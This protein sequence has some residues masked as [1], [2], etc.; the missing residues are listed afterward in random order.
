MNE[1]RTSTKFSGATAALRGYEFQ[2]YSIIYY[3]LLRLEIDPHLKVAI[4]TAQDA[5]IEYSA[6]ES[7]AVTELVQCKKEEQRGSHGV[8]R[9]YRNDS[10]ELGQFTLTDLRDWLQKKTEGGLSVKSV[11]GSQQSTF[12]TALLLTEASSDLK[13]FA[14]WKPSKPSDVRLWERPDF[15]LCFP[16]AFRHPRDQIR[17]LAKNIATPAIREKIRVLP[18]A[19]WAELGRA[20]EMLLREKFGIPSANIQPAVLKLRNEYGIRTLAKDPSEKLLTGAEIAHVLDDFRVDRAQWTDAS[21]WLRRGA[22]ALRPSVPDARLDWADFEAGRYVERLEFEHAERALEEDGFV[23]IHGHAGGGKTSLARLLAYRLLSRDRAFRG[24]VLEIKPGF[25]LQGEEHFLDANLGKPGVFLIE[26]SHFA[27][28]EVVELLEVFHAAQM[29]RRTRA[30]V[31]VTTAERYGPRQL[32]NREKQNDPHSYAAAFNFEPL[33][34]AE[35]TDFIDRYA[36]ARGFHMPLPAATVAGLAGGRVAVALVILR[37]ALDLA[38]RASVQKLL[39]EEAVAELLRDWILDKTGLADR[40]QLFEK[41]LVPVF[42]VTAF[43]IAPGTRFAEGIEILVKAGLRG[44]EP[45]VADYALS[46]LIT[47]HYRTHVVQSFRTLIEHDWRSIVPVLQRLAREPA[48]RTVLRELLDGTM[49]YIATT[50]SD[51][52]RCMSLGDVAAVLN[53]AHRVEQAHALFGEIAAPGGD[54]NLEFWDR[55]CSIER[56]SNAASIGA[57]FNAL[58]NANRYLLRRLARDSRPLNERHAELMIGVLLRSP[59]LHDIAV[60]LRG[61]YRYSRDFAHL[62][63]DQLEGSRIFQQRMRDAIQDMAALPDLVRYCSTLYSID[64]QRVGKVLDRAFTVS[65]LVSFFVTN[66]DRTGAL[67]V[68]NQ[69]SGARPR[70][71]RD[72]LR[73]TWDGNRGALIDQCVKQTD[74]V[75]FAK[76]IYFVSLLNRRVARQLAAATQQ[77]AATLV[78]KLTDYQDAASELQMMQRSLAG[79]YA[80]SVADSLDAEAMLDS[81]ANTTHRFAN[82]G[83]A[84]AT[85]AGLHPQLAAWLEERLSLETLSR[86]IERNHLFNLSELLNGFVRAAPSHVQRKRI[87]EYCRHGA[88]RTEFTQARKENRS[89]TQAAACLCLLTEIS[90]TPDDIRTLLGFETWTQ[91][92][93]DLNSRLAVEHSL[94]SLSA[95]L[96]Q[97]ALIRPS[98]AEDALDAYVKKTQVPPAKPREMSGRRFK[99]PSREQLGPYKSKLRDLVAVGT[100]LQITAMINPQSALTLAQS[101]DM[102]DLDMIAREEM[103]L[104]RLA[105]LLSGLAE[106][107]RRTALNLVERFSTDRSRVAQLE[108]N[109]N[110]R[111]V[112]H[113]A[114]T[115]TRVS[116]QAGAEYVDFIMPKIGHDIIE[117]ADA[118]ANVMEISNWLRVLRAKEGLADS[119]LVARLTPCLDE[120]KEYDSQIRHLLEAAEALTECNQRQHAQR[121]ADGAVDE[122]RQVSSIRKLRDFI[123]ILQKALWLESQ[124]RRHAFAADVF[125]PLG[126]PQVELMFEQQASDHSRGSRILV[127]F[128]T[129]LLSYARAPG[130]ERFAAVADKARGVLLKERPNVRPMENAL[131][132]TLCDGPAEWLHQCA[133]NTEWTALAERALAH[134]I[135]KV[136]R[137]ALTVSFAAAIEHEL[138]AWAN[139]LPRELSPHASNVEFALTYRLVESANCPP[140]LLHALRNEAAERAK[141][142]AAGAIRWIL[143]DFDRTFEASPSWYIWSILHLTA[144]RRTYLAWEDSIASFAAAEATGSKTGQVDLVALST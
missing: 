27:L 62:L 25:K 2:A 71:V 100:M 117:F 14:P 101:I 85:F 24:F 129:H 66:G 105:V 130:L 144:L 70:V 35:L 49:H 13:K 128:A 134:A 54:E 86:R 58:F 138:S 107:S 43:W 119:P 142:E 3:T 139:Q 136:T 72:A 1:P 112:W 28:G 104:G 10:V 123:D 15:N 47:N 22:E 83:R 56:M 20:C 5:L 118:E 93:Q 4:E 127:A 9:G 75:A 140:R 113:F 137:P 88:V 60:A 57:F 36:S 38:P 102:R 126:T 89:L 122:S 34:Q 44:L 7:P 133:A 110:L 33:S 132:T 90:L 131:I 45:E 111:N 94:R 17:A 81:L 76:P 79:R 98:V 55:F 92:D 67:V 124:L 106:T 39:N 84:L 97:V 51:D 30:K 125:A 65:R 50:V 80:H 42:S 64:R 32:A 52:S 61:I 31:I 18:L 135:V 121:F 116:K 29:G 41:L 11:L 108:E 143:S 96:Y 73:H 77:H 21:A 40:P 103:N 59:S 82:A 141:D 8:R 91:F 74:F 115:L 37:T 53:A 26:D 16:L 109:E 12:F 48:G 23:V 114:R 87:D 68:L 120:A 6:D 95:G 69:L 99:P 63:S 19:T 46:Y 78:S